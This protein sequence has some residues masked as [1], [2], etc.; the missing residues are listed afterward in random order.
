MT[1]TDAGRARQ[2]LDDRRGAIVLMAVF[3]ASF[4]VGGLWYIMGV[5]DAAMHRQALQTSADTT[6]YISA[7]Y[8]ARGMNIIAMVN[9]I[10]GAVMAI[11]A[12][13][14]MVQMIA[15]IVMAAANA[16]CAL[17][18]IPAYT[19]TD[20]V[21]GDVT[22]VDYSKWGWTCDSAKKAQALWD[23]MKSITIAVKTQ[24][25]DLLKGLSDAQKE[26]AKTAPWVASSQSTGVA[27]DYAPFAASGVAV[28][29]S[30]SPNVIRYGLPVMDMPF[31]EVCQMGGVFVGMIVTSTLPAEFDYF[32]GKML[33][34]IMSKIPKNI[35][36]G[37]PQ[38]G[39]TWDFFNEDDVCED[40][41]PGKEKDKCKDD[42]EK[43]DDKP[44][45]PPPISWDANDEKDPKKPYTPAENGNDYFQVYST[46]YAGDKSL[47]ERSDKGV[48]IAAWGKSK[49]PG[50]GTMLENLAIAQAEFYYDQ[51]AA[52]AVEDICFK[53]GSCGLTWNSYKDEVLWNLRW[54]ARLRRFRPPTGSAEVNVLSGGVS[55]IGLGKY[56]DGI[57]TFNTFAGGGTPD[58]MWT[59]TDIADMTGGSGFIGGGSAIIH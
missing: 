8:H 21:T 28:S 42:L 56:E 36:T 13:A 33:G 6:A 34:N 17:S 46:V 41:K 27:A 16:M 40:K 59:S 58:K 55:G 57:S 49:V 7:V 37:Q 2:L 29:I 35:C 4:L 10:M 18:K 25:E 32:I 20:P 30:M 50:T 48:D 14:Q 53:A 43:D 52:A 44:E 22:T 1:T 23:K 19:M 12:A 39:K 45:Q 24:A 5:G 11:A 51:T 54:R 31:E 47:L 26:V 38:S 15:G 9:L 3:M